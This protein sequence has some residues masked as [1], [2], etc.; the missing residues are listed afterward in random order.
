MGLPCSLAISRLFAYPQTRL[1]ED[2]QTARNGL[3][4][5]GLHQAEEHLQPFAGDLTM[6]S[7]HELQERY[8][9][10]F[11]LTGDTT[12]ELGWHLFGEQ[13]ARGIYLSK[14]RGMLA[15]HHI[16]EAGC[17]PDHLIHALHLLE[18]L[19]DD[20]AADFM[21]ACVQPACATLRTNLEKLHSSYIFPLDAFASICTA[22]LVARAA[23]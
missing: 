16:D 14:L 7:L 4:Q 10:T 19:P 12:L 20:A 8:T 23:S 22:T 18:L 21:A 13:Y 9:Q 15:D 1:I 3:R 17:L 6:R 2:L 5:A 11:D